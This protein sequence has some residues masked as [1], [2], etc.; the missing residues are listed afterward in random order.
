LYIHAVTAPGSVKSDRRSIVLICILLFAVAFGVR[1][2]GIGWGLKNSLHNQSYHPDE[3]LIFDFVHKSHVYRGPEE[4]E[5]YNYG[6]LFY[7]I[8]RV[9]DV[10]GQTFGGIKRPSLE[11]KDVK[12]PQDWDNLNAYV[13][14]CDLWGRIASALFGAG[15]A[16]LVFLIM[17]RWVTQVGAIAGAALIIFAPAHVEHSRFQTVDIISLFF[18]ALAALAAVRLLRPEL[19]DPKKWFGEVILA[20]A[21]AGCAGSTRYSDALMVLAVMMA[22]A[23]RRPKGWVWMA[24]SAPFVAIIAFCLTTPGV[25]TDSSYFWSNFQFQATHANTGHGL[26]FVGRPSG[27]IYQ[28]Y[29]LM[30]GISILG[31]VFGIGGLLYAAIRKHQWAWVLLAY[32]VPYLIS[33]GTLHVMFLRYGFPLYLGVACGFAYAISAIS[34]RANKS[35]VGVAVA[36]MA[37]LSIENPQGGIRGT[38]LFTQ[39]MTGT[40]P[41]DAAGHY[42]A[43]LSKLTPNLDIGILGSSPWFWSASIMKD[44]AYVEFLPPSQQQQIL[45]QTRD[46]HVVSLMSGQ[47]PMYMT[48]SSYEIEDAAR[49]KG[50]T[51]LDLES[52]SEV[53]LGQAKMEAVDQLYAPDR[54][55]GGDGPTIHDLEYIRPTV[56][57]VKRR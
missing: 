27:F 30:I 25:V 14:Q 54:V 12:S 5:Y 24:A 48:Y 53:Q 8:L 47:V 31:V 11:L 16:V 37:L 45:A 6:T 41:R 33:I 10:A 7:A 49:L 40:D 19:R 23:V 57:I 29:E 4:R 13:S 39:W 32:F 44:A 38:I 55:F 9:A 46:P 2:P 17:R 34:L 43:D 56:W 36:A 3:P 35:W 21:L 26:V 52:M 20:A 18:V 15:T 51:D 1:L 42:I 50:R 28:I 22:V